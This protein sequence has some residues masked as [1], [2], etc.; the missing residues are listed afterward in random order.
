[1]GLSNYEDVL[2]A[3]RT[4]DIDTLVA[5]DPQVLHELLQD[6]ATLEL[7]A[8]EIACE[9]G[10]IRHLVY[11]AWFWSTGNRELGR[12]GVPQ[13]VRDNLR[14]KPTFEPDPFAGTYGIN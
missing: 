5:E 13:V 7:V 8:S 2:Q 10:D 3:L 1:M 12:T 14:W 9:V 4:D 11:T 6:R